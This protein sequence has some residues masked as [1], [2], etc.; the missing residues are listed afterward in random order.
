VRLGR[1]TLVKETAGSG[2]GSTWI[3]R[4]DA[5]AG[6][7]TRLFSLLRF[8]KHVTKKVDVAEAI[9][10]EAR[11]AQKL[12]HDKVVA[13]VET[14]VADGEVF[15]VSDWV[16]GESWAGLVA[17]AGNEGLPVEVSVRLALD[18][19]EALQAAH[20][21]G[22]EVLVHGELN[23]WQVLIG[24]DGVAHVAGFGLA[25]AVARIGPHGVKNHDRLAYGAPERVK[26]MGGAAGSKVSAEPQNDVFSLAAMLW[27]SLARQRLFSSKMEAA[28]VQK[29][30]TAP[31]PE[32]PASVPMTL[33]DVVKRGL[34]RDPQK[35][36]PTPGA[37]AKDLEAASDAA[38]REQVAAALARFAGKAMASRRADI[39]AALEQGGGTARGPAAPR[40]RAATLVGI[41]ARDERMQTPLAYGASSGLPRAPVTAPK[42]EP[43]AVSTGW[44]LPAPAAPSAEADPAL[45][46]GALAPPPAPSVTE[47]GEA[48]VEV[49][50]EP[51]GVV[52]PP[53]AATSAAPPPP[54]RQRQQSRPRVNTLLGFVPPPGTEAGSRFGNGA[55]KPGGAARAEV[56]A[57]GRPGVAGPRTSTRPF[58]SAKPPPAKPALEPAKPSPPLPAATPIPLAS[59]VDT[60]PLPP[61]PDPVAVSKVAAAEPSP[62]PSPSPSTAATKPA[63]AVAAKPASAVAAKPAPAVAAKP[64]LAARPLA[65]ARPLPKATAPAAKPQPFSAKKLGEALFA[66]KDP[67]RADAPSGAP[68]PLAAKKFEPAARPLAEASP[69]GPPVATK[70]GDSRSPVSGKALGRVGEAIDRLRPG[71]TLGRYEIL[72]PAAQ[73]GMASVWAARLQGSRGFQKT[74]AIKT[75]LPDVSDDPDFESMFLDE[76]RVA[77]KIRHPNVA[78]ILELGEENDVLYLVMEWVEGET[79]GGLQRA[80]KAHGGVPLPIVLRIAS[81]V[82]AGLHAA[83]ELRDDQGALLDLIHRDISPANVIVSTQGFVK[84]VDFGIAKSKGRMHVT[85]AGDMIKG[86]TPYLSPEQLGSLVIDRRSDIFSLGALLYVLTTGLH[87]FRGDTDLKT[88]ENIALRAPVPLRDILPDL[89]PEF[90]KVVLK[91]LSKEPGQRYATAAEMQRAIDQVASR[92]GDPVTDADVAA[93]LRKVVGEALDKRSAEL[94]AAI[95]NADSERQTEP[96]PPV[97]VPAPPAPGD[98]GSHVIEELETVDIVSSRPAGV[99]AAVKDAPR[100]LPPVAARH[101]AETKPEGA[102]DDGVDI[103]DIGMDS[104]RPPRSEA[105]S[106]ASRE[107][108]AAAEETATVPLSSISSR[109]PPPSVEQA[110]R[111]QVARLAVVGSLVGCALLGVLALAMSGDDDKPAT[112]VAVAPPSRVESPPPTPPAETVAVA[113]PT[114]PPPEPPAPPP[115]APEPVVEPAPP[116][117]VAA[118]KP[119]APEKPVAKPPAPAKPPAVAA[120]PPV[121][122]PPSK[123]P[124]KPAGTTKKYNPKGI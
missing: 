16:E 113:P 61:L 82:C 97:T 106:E 11:H 32:L 122:K 96:M 123:P 114:P 15:V 98:S 68:A 101:A 64:A 42:A 36:Y 79:V 120:K 108:E 27:E 93:F 3:A 26:Q 19:L 47:L 57:L 87:P 5:D 80:A 73:G 54:P 118:E 10:Q 77:A 111:K 28:V 44:T 91:A 74:V 20:D 37:M 35:R 21:L 51:E 71:S 30:L 6:G 38:S 52:V 100:E 76:A 58:A 2:V 107:A 7:P 25:R 85:R 115:T 39:D 1:Y 8:H 117:K 31:I 78:E 95:S 83:H 23:P 49:V 67:T 41:P 55:P 17:A 9:L 105:K 60:K 72:M 92:L 75:M 112:P 13:V 59:V 33:G 89:D 45:A 90:E 29:V 43:A 88:V 84:V 50:A 48:D 66:K 46:A 86:K 69:E 14:G 62:S 12:R 124:A 18:A 4:S 81:Q 65:G 53:P 24:T 22:T 99:A 116:P 103:D 119:S 109:P 121:S 110:R 34:E 56:P 70:T 40:P 102:L 63:P 94:R 104:V